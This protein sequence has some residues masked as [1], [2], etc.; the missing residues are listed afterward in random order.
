MMKKLSRM[1]GRG[2]YFFAKHLPVSTS[3]YGFLGRKLRY[4]A[5]KRI[6]TEIGER[7]NIEKDTV[8]ASDIHIGNDSALGVRSYI[9]T[10]TVIGNDVMMGP[11]CMIFTKNHRFDRVDIPMRKQGETEVLPVIIEDDVWLG[12]RVL[13]LPGARVGSGSVIGAG[14]V[15]SGEIPP[16]S[17]AVGNPARVVK[18]RE[19]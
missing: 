14:A 6:C 9:E 1:F 5:A 17:V 16:M 13:L 12:A 4:F 11:E 15:V 10:G 8:F 3:K 18:R 7:V 2:I 19:E